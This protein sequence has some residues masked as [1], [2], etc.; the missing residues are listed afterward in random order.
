[1]TC[2]K[3]FSF[4]HVDSKENNVMTCVKAFSFYHVAS[5]GYNVMT[6]VKALSSATSVQYQ[7]RGTVVSFCYSKPSVP[8]RNHATREAYSTFAGKGEGY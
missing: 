1:M 7:K 6:C 3:A 8:T 4:D 2:V 5:K